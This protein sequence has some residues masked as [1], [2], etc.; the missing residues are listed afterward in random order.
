MDNDNLNNED[1]NLD[2]SAQSSSEQISSDA[3]SAS[4]VQVDQKSVKKSPAKKVAKK[5]AKKAPK[6]AETKAEALFDQYGE[7]FQKVGDLG[8][9]II[10]VQVNRE[11]STLEQLKKRIDKAGLGKYFKD[12][13]IPTE[14]VKVFRGGKEREEKHKL[15][16]GYLFVYMEIN[17]YTWF[18]VRETPGMGDFTTVS[19]KPVPM[20]EH[21]VERMLAQEKTQ[22]TSD[23]TY[24]F[25]YAVGDHVRVN[26]GTFENSEGEVMKID[27]AAG[28]VTVNISIFSRSTPVELEHWQVEKVG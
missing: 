1:S 8:W 9:Y 15:Y 6:K 14:T 23:F 19:G 26:N 12:F 10:K 25:K 21:E 17:S 18:V 11:E 13:K 5:A 4:S 22:G 3:A 7:E 16:P 20:N 24:K 28:R 27:Q 2:A